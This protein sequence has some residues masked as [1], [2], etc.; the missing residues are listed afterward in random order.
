MTETSAKGQATSTE[1]TRAGQVL[2]RRVAESRATIPAFELSAVLDVA[3]RDE[4]P[5]DLVIAAAARALRQ[6]PQANAAYRDG[7]VETFA[8]VNVAVAITVGD[9]LVAPVIE[10]ADQKSVE[11]I[12]AQRREHADA[13]RAGTLASPHMSGATFTVQALEVPS[14]APIVTPGQAAALG[15]G[16][17]QA[18]VVAHE[19]APAVRDTVAITLACDHRALFGEAAAAFLSAVCAAA[20]GAR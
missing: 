4:E 5:V 19:G 15:V 17:R 3:G 16:A 10:D 11:E 7:R 2:A 14:F 12:A 6:H 8:R 20:S 18:R 13:A 1:L 9:T